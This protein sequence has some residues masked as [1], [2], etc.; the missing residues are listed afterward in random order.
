MGFSFIS[1]LLLL[2]A[3]YWGYG[4]KMYLIANVTAALVYSSH[5]LVVTRRKG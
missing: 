4:H 1:W 5:T 2:K 3:P